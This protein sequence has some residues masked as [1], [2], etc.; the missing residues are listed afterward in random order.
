MCLPSHKQDHRKFLII[1]LVLG[2]LRSCSMSRALR[3]RHRGVGKWQVQTPG[4]A[5]A[6]PKHA[7]R[8]TREPCDIGLH[9]EIIRTGNIYA[10]TC[11]ATRPLP[12]RNSLQAWRTQVHRVLS[13]SNP[14]DISNTFFLV[15]FL[16]L[17]FTYT[18]RIQSSK[19]TYFTYSMFTN[20]KEPSLK[21]SSNV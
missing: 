5:K 8:A 6:H 20:W 4:Q 17:G 21:C 1:S 14:C 16:F 7:G 19:F 15:L 11:G 2:P 12:L 10:V 9:H 13:P 18:S 3:A